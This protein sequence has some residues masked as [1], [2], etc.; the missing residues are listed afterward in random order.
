MEGYHGEQEKI[1]PHTH[2]YARLWIRLEDTNREENKYEPKREEEAY[3]SR[4]QR[5]PLI[6]DIRQ[7]HPCCVCDHASSQTG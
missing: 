4:E 5:Y 6:A 2:H 7:S 3:G 1:Q